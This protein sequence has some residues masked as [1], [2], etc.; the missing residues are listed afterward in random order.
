MNTTS[1]GGG[2]PTQGPVSTNDPSSKS[3][4]YLQMED[5]WHVVRSIYEG[6]R[7]MRKQRERYLPKHPEENDDAYENRLKRTSL[8]NVLKDAVQNTVARPFSKPVHLNGSAPKE[9]HLWALDMDL[10]GTGI[11]TFCRRA[12]RDATLDGM[13]HCL[14]DYNV[15]PAGAS[16]AEKAMFAQRPYLTLVPARNLHAA[17]TTN[18]MGQRICYHARI[19]EDV[20]VLDGFREKKV[21][22]MRVLNVGGFE[23]WER[24]MNTAG[25]QVVQR[26]EMRRPDGAIWDRVPLETFYAGPREQDFLCPP[27][28]L[29]LAWLNVVHWQSF[30]DQRNILSKSRFAMLYLT[31]IENPDEMTDDDGNF[32]VGPHAG[33]FLPDGGSIGYVEP[34]GRSIEMGFKDLDTLVEQMRVMGLDPI[35]P[36]GGTPNT[37][38]EMS[39]DDAKAR[40]PLEEWA[41][42]F[43]AFMERN[44]NNMF[45]WQGM[46]QAV[47]ST[48]VEINTDFGVNINGPET[49]Q[50]IMQMRSMGELS[51]RTFYYEMKRRSVLSPSFDADTEATYLEDE[52]L[53]KLALNQSL[54]LDFTGEPIEEP[55]PADGGGD[56][57]PSDPKPK[58]P[59]PAES[60][61]TKKGEPKDP[62]RS[63]GGNPEPAGAKGKPKPKR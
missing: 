43:V 12:F 17:Y 57:P 49:L 6:T 8:V 53:E 32:V 15:A 63:K 35:M 5:D 11:N 20:T 52:A 3:S 13:V 38:T 16:P 47:E 7:H 30:S 2:T 51:R 22:R 56:N 25:W 4:T 26:G 46:D 37:A 28:F 48:R 23:V 39:I 50:T 61:A 24:G 27:P 31:G 42:D 59:T 9:A 18:S 33:I 45:L 44:Y 55:D 60:T 40:A 14:A 58:T 62:E 54:G 19:R 21:E 29:D 10:E 34:G 1:T 41:W 36:K